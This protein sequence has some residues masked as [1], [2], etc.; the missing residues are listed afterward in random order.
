MAVYILDSHPV[1]PDPECGDP[2]G[3]LAVGGDLSLE[4]LLAAYEKGIFPWYDDNNPILW[5]SP[6]PRLILLPHQL[7]YPR[8]LRRLL[9][10]NPFR[11][12]FDRAFEAVI[13]NCSRAL[14]PYGPGTWLTEEMIEAFIRLHLAGYAHSVEAWSSDGLAGGLYGVSLGRAFYGESM[15]RRQDGAS[16]VCLVR[17]ARELESRGVHFID[18][19]QTTKHMQ[20]VG[21]FEVSGREF[22]VRLEAALGYPTLMGSWASWSDA[23]VSLEG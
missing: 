13:R 1:F 9:R 15:F 17:L 16:K 18:C 21:A 5:W 10:V 20:A 8:N 11:I 7:R 6:S 14:R 2:D 22:R 12:T 4:R 19:Q 3:L 23:E